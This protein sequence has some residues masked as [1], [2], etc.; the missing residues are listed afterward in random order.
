MAKKVCAALGYAGVRVLAGDRL[1]V[2]GGALVEVDAAND[3][4]G[5]VY[6]NWEPSPE[7]SKTVRDSLMAGH[8]HGPVFDLYGSI[9]L[10]MRNAL[11]EVLR[12]SGFRV[13]P[14][15]DA[16]GEPTILVLGLNSE[17]QDPLA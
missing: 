7:L 14:V 9:S 10:S 5:G 16:G 15:D 2:E 4:A 3:E 17:M 13:D 8:R 11:T 6:V 1:P 12:H